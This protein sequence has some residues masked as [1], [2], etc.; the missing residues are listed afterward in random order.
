M[1]DK[2]WTSADEA[3]IAAAKEK[4]TILGDSGR[5][6]LCK[7]GTEHALR[8]TSEATIDAQCKNL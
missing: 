4:E 5:I 1:D 6:L 3:I 8:V 2:G 7:S